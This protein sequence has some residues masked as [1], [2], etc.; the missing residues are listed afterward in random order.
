MTSIQTL[1][2]PERRNLARWAADCAGRVLPLFEDDVPEENRIPEALARTRDYA[3]GGSST[4]EEISRRM[5]AVKADGSATS[6]A[7]AAVGRA[8]AQAAAVAHMGAYALSAAAYAVK[9]V[10][11]EHP[12]SDTRVET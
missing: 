12:E 9:A 7:A 1:S 4:K 3:A 6:P 11:L 5:V 2:D 10:S 8:V